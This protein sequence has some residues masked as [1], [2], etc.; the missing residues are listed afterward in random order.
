MVYSQFTDG[1]IASQIGFMNT[2][3]RSQEIMQTCAAVFL[4]VD[5]DLTNA[6][7]IVVACPFMCAVTDHVTNAV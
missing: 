1:G 5:M 3:I 4:G 2:A 7:A 6:I